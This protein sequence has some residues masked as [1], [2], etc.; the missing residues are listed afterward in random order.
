MNI[1]TAK[2]KVCKDCKTELSLENF[3][4]DFSRKDGYSIKCKACFKIYY[5]NNKDRLYT[6]K[7]GLTSKKEKK[8]KE[9]NSARADFITMLVRNKLE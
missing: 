8:L 7:I 3:S 6:A 1:L 4:H 9:L 2:T 5:H